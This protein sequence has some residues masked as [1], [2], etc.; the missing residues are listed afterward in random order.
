MFK[1][2]SLHNLMV[3]NFSFLSNASNVTIGKL[4]DIIVGLNSFEFSS[5]EEFEQMAEID[6]SDLDHINMTELYIRVRTS[7]H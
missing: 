3:F 1:E 2:N 5:F 6:L 7:I 4:T